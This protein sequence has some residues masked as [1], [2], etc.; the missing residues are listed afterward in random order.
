M[1]LVLFCLFIFNMN[2]ENLCSC[3]AGIMPNE[4]DDVKHYK[5]KNVLP[6]KAKDNKS[7]KSIIGA[8]KVEPGHEL[9]LYIASQ[10]I[11]KL[12]NWTLIDRHVINVVG[13]VCE[14]NPVNN[15]YDS[16]EQKLWPHWKD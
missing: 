15:E 5:S 9:D 8:W 11:T 2:I 10:D 13:N 12:V 6:L 14:G 4:S 1:R 16:V 3:M 7:V